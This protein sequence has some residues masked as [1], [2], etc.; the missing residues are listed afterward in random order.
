MLAERSQVALTLQRAILGPVSLPDSFAV[1]YEP[2]ISQVGGD[3]YDVVPLPEG[4]CGVVVG[5]VVGHGLDAAAVMGQLRSAARALLLQDHGPA[6]VL[7]SLDTFAAMLPGA[8]CTTV[9][10]AV[11]DPG[12]QVVVYCSAGHLPALVVDPDGGHRWLDGALS[13]PLAVIAGVERVEASAALPADATLLLY[14]DGLVERRDDV[15][16]AGLLRTAEVVVRHRAS[17]LDALADLLVR[18]LMDPGHDDD[19]ALLLYRRSGGTG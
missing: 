4:R 2:A 17:S 10:C 1:R 8:R 7:S 12:D 5:D 6:S 14:T 16:D 11:I 18:D 15:L 19:V 9:F 13:V 3:W